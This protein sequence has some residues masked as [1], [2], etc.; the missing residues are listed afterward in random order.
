MQKMNWL[1]LLAFLLPSCLHKYRSV[2]D[3]FFVIEFRDAEPP[4]VVYFALS[5]DQIGSRYMPSDNER[6]YVFVG[7]T[8]GKVDSLPVG[9]DQ[10]LTVSFEGRSYLCYRF[11]RPLDPSEYVDVLFYDNKVFKIR[12]LMW[13]YY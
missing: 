3:Y 9:P 11:R 8:L 6:Q 2:D 5:S 4:V 1:V 13:L 10:V 7:D 12:G